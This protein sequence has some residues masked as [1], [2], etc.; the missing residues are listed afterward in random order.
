MFKWLREQWE[1]LVMCFAVWLLDIF[2]QRK[3]EKERKKK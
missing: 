3:E 1:W 2:E